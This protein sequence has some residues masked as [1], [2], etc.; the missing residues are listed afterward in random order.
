[1]K[2]ELEKYKFHPRVMELR[3]AMIKNQLERQYGEEVAM[4]LLKMLSDMFQCNWSLLVSVFN[5]D[6]KIMNHTSVGPKRKKQEIILMG[7][8]YNETRYYISKHYLSMSTNYL[9]QSKFQHNPEVYADES[10][11]EP[12]DSEVLACGVRAYA[13]EA[14]RFIVSFDSFLGVFK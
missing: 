10:W 8:L 13:L 4:N 11:L 5:K 1:M 12:M 3:M 2:T 7:H 9:Y 6:S 14:K